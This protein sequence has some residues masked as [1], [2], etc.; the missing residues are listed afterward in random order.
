M[1]SDSLDIEPYVAYDPEKPWTRTVVGQQ[2]MN[3]FVIFSMEE[4]CPI[5]LHGNQGE[6]EVQAR[7]SI[8]AKAGIRR[9]VDRQPCDAADKMFRSIAV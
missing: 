1:P 4:G 9:T 3:R 5:A 6:I 8:A 2:A 7:Q